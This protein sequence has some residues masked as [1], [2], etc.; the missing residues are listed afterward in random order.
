M[1]ERA[2]MWLRVSSTEQDEA[3]QQPTCERWIDGH[4]YELG[5]T[6]TVHG[7]SAF[8]G[9]KKFDETWASVLDYFRTG[10]IQVLVV[11]KLDRI[12]RKLEA[13]RMIKDVVA[14]GGRVEFSDQ[15]HLNDLSTM[16]GRIALKIQEEIAYEES[17]TKSD[18]VVAKFTT[19]RASNGLIGRA[20]F[21]YQISGV[22]WNKGLVPTDQGRALI[23]A[24]FRRVIAGDSLRTIAAWLEI[25]TTV[26]PL[27][28]KA[29]W[30][31]TVGEL[32]KNPVYKGQRRAQN[33][34]TMPYTWGAI[35]HRCEP[36]VTAREWQLANQAL[37]SHP[38]RGPDSKGTR[39]M[40]AGALTCPNCGG[41]SPMYRYQVGGGYTYYRCTGKGRAR[42]GCGNMI[43]TG[44]VDTAV[45]R[46]IAETFTTPV[47]EKRLVPGQDWT[48]DIENVKAEIREL[49]GEDLPDDEFDRRMA[50][51]RGVRDELAA[52]PVVADEIRLVPTGDTYS[53]LWAALPAPERGP[54]LRAQG[55][56]VLADKEHV[57]V[58][59]DGVT[60][61][62]EIGTNDHPG[63]DA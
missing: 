11:W 37:K 23:P 18:R 41:H 49:A 25:Q 19:M 17:K 63:Q 46:I 2:G 45:C 10:Q 51:L 36:L 59:Q 3:S 1:G 5:P 28:P 44:K 12:D 30:P 40:L 33:R 9:N 14:L 47:Y 48:T 34:N 35:V 32:I 56:R 53:G 39:A 6:Y 57:T 16:A 22:K 52:R 31:A 4:G 27:V 42:R 43:A 60:A 54:W 7:G 21:G 8:K 26:P 24:V 20:P 58:I 38:G 29:W 55:F 50:E 61:T 13:L 15:P 62:V